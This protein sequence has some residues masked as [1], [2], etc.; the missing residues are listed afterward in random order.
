MLCVADAAAARP[1]EHVPP[2]RPHRTPRHRGL[3]CAGTPRA[4]P[5][6][7]A[8]PLRAFCGVGG[9]GGDSALRLRDR[10]IR[11]HANFS[12]HSIRLLLLAWHLPS[13]STY[14]VHDLPI[15]SMAM[16]ARESP[17][18]RHNYLAQRVEDILA[19]KAE[20]EMS[21]DY[22]QDAN[23]KLEE[24]VDK[25][26]ERVD[27]VEPDK[28]DLAAALKDLEER[29]DKL[30]E[31]VD[32]VEPDKADL[33]AALKDLEERVDKLEERADDMEPD[34]ADLAATLEDLEERVVK[35]EYD[36]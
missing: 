13:A 28:A 30:E 24:R 9:G 15:P 27:D 29:V 12:A 20:L 21:V 23:T 7:H 5:M 11:R 33:A 4:M 36:A 6:G 16:P 17:E 3:P 22:L 14:M 35:L 34:K 32:D 10:P 1:F 2:A 8:L 31:R 26:E 18:T 25:L 19:E